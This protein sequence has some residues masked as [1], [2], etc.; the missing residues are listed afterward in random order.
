M[1]DK[2]EIRSKWLPPIRLS[3]EERQKLND[4][5]SRSTCNS[6]SEYA[7]KVLLAEP[8]KIFYRNQSIDEFVEE[9]IGLKNELSAI[10]KNFNQAVHRL[11]ML[12]HI[13]EIKHG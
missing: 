6:M 5:F 2:K 12:D 13:S 8:V 9:I 3:E 4:F 7:R 11:H 1:Q 10:G